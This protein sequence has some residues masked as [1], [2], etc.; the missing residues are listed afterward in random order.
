MKRL[1]MIPVFAVLGLMAPSLMPAQQSKVEAEV[2]ALV[3]E[4]CKINVKGDAAAL[5]K[6]LAS[7]FVRIR[8]NGLVATKAD[9]LDW[10]R[11]GNIKM[12]LDEASDV[13]AYAHGDAAVV[14]STESVKG[15]LMGKEYGGKYLDSRVFVR[16]GGEWK[17]VLHQSTRIAE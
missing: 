13:K 1:L 4:T 9:L 12:S 16:R 3:E 10:F 15:V 14:T 17:E 7:D 2:R 6:H 5:D 11:T 8:S